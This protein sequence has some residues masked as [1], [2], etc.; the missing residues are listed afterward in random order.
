MRIIKCG[1][2]GLLC[3]GLLLSNPLF[4]RAEGTPPPAA[5]AAPTAAEGDVA[6]S[7]APAAPQPT[8]GPVVLKNGSSGDDVILLQMRLR[9]LGYFNYKITDYFGSLTEQ[10]VM[11]FQK[12][13]DLPQDGII[14]E[15]TSGVLFSNSA[16][17][18]PV[19]AVTQPVKTHDGSTVPIGRKADWYKE[20]QYAFPRRGT[21]TVI[22]VYTGISYNVDRVGGSKH[23]DV[24]PL[25]KEDTAKL[26]ASYGGAW[27]WDRRP[28][29]VKINGEWIAGS[30]N[31]M[32]HGYETVAGNGMD[33][34]VCIHFLNSRTHI[35]NLTDAAHQARVRIAAGE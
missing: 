31:G 13:N 30:I 20:V 26:K 18:K 25:T 27:S 23:A 33:G 5:S 17:R 8:E 14:G 3:V 9:D 22:D 19:E 29:V 15:Q 24:E 7:G 35:R 1:L 6:P 12:Q 16:K 32:P 28:V 10:G 21:A 11:A 34:Q 4:A 2:C